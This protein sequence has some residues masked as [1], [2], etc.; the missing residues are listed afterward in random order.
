MI[1]FAG[2]PCQRFKRSN[3]ARL[4][5]PRIESRFG[6]NSISEPISFIEDYLE[7]FPDNPCNRNQ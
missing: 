1:P 2:T 6:N 3:A 5:S 7:S 4:K